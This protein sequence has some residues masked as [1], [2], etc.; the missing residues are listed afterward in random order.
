[1]RP[2]LGKNDQQWIFDYTIRMTGK[3]AH[4]ELDAM[5]DKLPPEVRSWDMI[6]KVLGKQA[7]R[8]ELFF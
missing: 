4:W 1:M 6:P 3:T 8:E 7:A 5:L 2:R